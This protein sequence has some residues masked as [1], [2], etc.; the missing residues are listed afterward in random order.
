MGEDGEQGQVRDRFAY[1]DE[2]GDLIEPA[3]PRIV[4]VAPRRWM[5]PYR[6]L[7]SAS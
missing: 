7:E 5:K 1:M 4:V 6:E 2:I 3:A